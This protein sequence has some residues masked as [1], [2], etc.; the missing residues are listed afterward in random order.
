MRLSKLNSAINMT[1]NS[2]SKAIV[3]GSAFAVMA[4]IPAHAFEVQ[5]SKLSVKSS[6]NEVV[7]IREV[8]GLTIN[9]LDEHKYTATYF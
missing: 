2:S 5:M 6:K 7:E 4:T 9:S 3:L 1:C 8:R